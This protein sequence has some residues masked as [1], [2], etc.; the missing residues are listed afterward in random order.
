[1]TMVPVQVRLTKKILGMIDEMV[2]RGMY[3]N[4]SEVIR[5]AIRRHINDPQRKFL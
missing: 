5:D 4:R 2:E 3:S 1:M